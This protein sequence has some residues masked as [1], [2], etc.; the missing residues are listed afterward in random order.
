MKRLAYMLAVIT[1][2]T[3]IYTFYKYGIYAGL[4]TSVT[5]VF[6]FIVAQ[7]LYAS[8]SFVIFAKNEGVKILDFSL[9]SDP[10]CPDIISSGFFGN[11]FIIPKFIIEEFQK[12][13]SSD[14]EKAKNE[15]RRG[16]DII[17][18]LKENDRIKI[19]IEEPPKLKN[20]S[21]SPLID[22]AVK[23]NSEIVTL[24]YEIT[25]LGMINNVKIL[26]VNDLQISLRQSFLPGDEFSIFVMKEGK[27]PNQG[28]GYLDDGTMVVIEKGNNYIGKKI[29]VIVQSVLKNTSGKIIF[30]RLK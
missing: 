10:R 17:A 21:G 30:T 18:R 27:D 15:A 12:K 7:M 24:D 16:L 4:I 3:V 9:L 8:E 2:I 11:N 25:K 1:L 5:A 28:V 29:N 14:D 23:T 22:M 19:R 26:N 20:S 6:S 13:A